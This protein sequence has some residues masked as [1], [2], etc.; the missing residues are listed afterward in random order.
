M[1]VHDTS[2]DNGIM[3]V[4]PSCTSGVIYVIPMDSLTF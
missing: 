3:L 4:S 2:L 1:I